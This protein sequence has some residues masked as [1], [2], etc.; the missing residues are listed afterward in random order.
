[1]VGFDDEEDDFV[2]AAFVVI[3]DDVV[4]LFMEGAI[5]DGDNVFGRLIVGTNVVGKL[6]KV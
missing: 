2:G 1:M 6:V 4:D 5:D 3:E